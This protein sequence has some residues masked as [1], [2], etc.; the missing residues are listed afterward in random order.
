MQDVVVEVPMPGGLEPL[1]PKVYTDPD[2]AT[3]CGRS[4]DEADIEAQPSRSGPKGR[5][6]F[7]GGGPVMVS[8]GVV[9]MPR[10]RRLAGAAAE[11]GGPPAG[12]PRRRQ[13]AAAALR[14]AGGAWM[15]WPPWPVCP[16]QE[17][18]PSVVTFRFS[19]LAAGTHS[20]RFRAIAA[21]PGSFVL[22]PVKAYVSKQP[23]VMGLSPGGNF[24]VCGARGAACDVSPQ[25][26]A[27]PP[28]ACP[29]ACGGNGVCNLA[30]GACICD[31]GFSGK[32]CDKLAAT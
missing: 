23:E 11:E 22:P 17:T 19:W 18:L 5:P 16:A 14:P 15:I 2:A 30:T 9:A 31:A 25:K 27:P 28:K 8:E 10:R 6:F 3:I 32:A 4:D 1:D 20:I 21:T 13:L 26:A 29:S 7:P 24:T 12:Y